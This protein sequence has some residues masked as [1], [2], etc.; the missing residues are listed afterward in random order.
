MYEAYLSIDDDMV[1]F[2]FLSYTMYT[3]EPKNDSELEEEIDVCGVQ[4]NE[5]VWFFLLEYKLNISGNLR[6]NSLK[7]SIFELRSTY[8]FFIVSLRTTEI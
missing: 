8:P 4:H 5:K 1:I 7:W 3:A 2:I 6:Y